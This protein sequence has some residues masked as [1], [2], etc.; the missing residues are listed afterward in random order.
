[1]KIAFT[2]GGT[3]GHFYPIIAVAE[4]I[5]E[6]SDREKIIGLKLYYFSDDKYDK[7]ALFE[8]GIEYRFITAGKRR[9][10]FSIENFFDIFKTAAGCLSALVSLFLVYPDVVFSKGGYSSFPVVLAARILRIPVVLHE[11]DT[12]PGRVNTWTGKFAEKIAISYD[13]AAQFFPKEKT[14]EVGQPIRKAIREKKTEG[15][16]EYFKIDPGIPTI[17]ILGG[18][19]GAVTINDIII[20]AL[21]VLL[22]DFQIIHQTG[23]KNFTDVKNRSNFM[24]AGNENINRYLPF[25]SLNPLSMKMA[26]GAA[27][28]VISRAGSTIFEIAAWG[29]PS[30]IIPISESNNDH[31][32]KN[33]FNYARHGAAEVIEENNLSTNILISEIKRFYDDPTRREK[34]EAAAKNFYVPDSAEKI[35]KVLLDIAISHT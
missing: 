35:A 13:E 29:L 18:S 7:E 33:A 6:I 24:L 8:N 34:M 31:Q 15:A 27:S 2:G 22:K 3:G 25:P 4:A 28:L 9:L 14:A 30:I 20:D 17:L 21:P 1:M 16:F 5:R 32:K 11:S 23:E 26:A 10:Y 19:Q 12:A